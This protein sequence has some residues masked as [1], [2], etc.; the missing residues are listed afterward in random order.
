MLKQCLIWVKSSLVLGRQDYQWQ[1]EPC[2]YG[3]K[4]GAA[5]YFT[6]SRTRTTIADHTEDIDVK[7]MK[8]DELQELINRILGLPT[9][10]I[11]HDKPKRSPLHPTMKPILLLA[12]FIENSTKP[13]EIVTDGCIGSGSTMVAAEQLG[14]SCYGIELEPYNCQN[15]IERMR[16]LDPALKITINGKKA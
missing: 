2:L 10:I 14:R 15:I 1:H 7:K 6:H 16:L 13:K 5:H 8:K 9:S 12:P 3:W 11:H 4:P